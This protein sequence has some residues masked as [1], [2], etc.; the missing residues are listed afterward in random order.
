[1]KMNLELS[2]EE[3]MKVV[4]A[5]RE[6]AV[7]Q[8]W[9]EDE[10]DESGVLEEYTSAV[11]AALTAM[12]ISVSIA[13]EPEDDD[14]AEDEDEDENEEVDDFGVPTDYWSEFDE[15]EDDD[16]DDDDEDEDEEDT[17]QYSLTPKGEF[18]IQ[19]MEAGY[20]FKEALTVANILW[21]EGE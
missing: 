18:V 20:S 19:F 2:F 11:D 16:E 10:L 12:G 5:L 4:N 8:G 1:M 15:D 7:Q 14:E 6:C 3:G 13:T 21:G 9:N 17:H